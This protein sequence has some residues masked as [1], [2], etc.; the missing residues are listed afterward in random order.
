MY[1]KGH[2]EATRLLVLYG[3]PREGDD[4]G[5]DPRLGVSVSRKVGGAT[6]R[7]RVKRVLREAFWELAGTVPSGHDYVIVARPDIKAVIE[8]AGL[9]G[10]RDALAEAIDAAGG[11]F[12]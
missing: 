3:F 1:R 9:S 6:D 8:R 7:N 10:A 12:T 11:R 5:D 2:G 4:D